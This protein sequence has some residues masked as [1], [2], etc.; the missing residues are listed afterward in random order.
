MAAVQSLQQG[1]SRSYLEGQCHHDEA[2]RRRASV[3]PPAAQRLQGKRAAGQSRYRLGLTEA[4]SLAEHCSSREAAHDMHLGEL[5]PAQSFS[6]EKGTSLENI[7]QHLHRADIRSRSQSNQE[8]HML[9]AA[10]QP[11]SGRPSIRKWHRSKAGHVTCLVGF[12]DSKSLRKV[13]ADGHELNASVASKVPFPHAHK[14]VSLQN[15]KPLL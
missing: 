1:S 4:G 12:Y 14:R 11:R 7:I 13:I 15:V 6:L 5:P 8:E 10:G 2:E 3:C 9:S